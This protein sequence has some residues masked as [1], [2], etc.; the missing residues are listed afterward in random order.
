[1][2]ILYTENR[3]GWKDDRY[4]DN[5]QGVCDIDGVPVWS[6]TEYNFNECDGVDVGRSRVE[7]G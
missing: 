6:Y 7:T 4:A 2:G 3:D 5:G 1:M